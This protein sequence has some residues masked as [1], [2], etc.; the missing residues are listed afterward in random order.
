MNE[1]IMIEKIKKAGELFNE[2]AEYFKSDLMSA[3]MLRSD[4][5]VMMKKKEMLVQQ[6]NLVVEESKNIRR[7]AEIYAQNIKREADELLE[8]A[9][10][11]LSDAIITKENKKISDKKSKEDAAINAKLQAVG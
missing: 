4:I 9:K 6:N 7:D 3:R 1:D 10:R 8:K 11:T 5:D 2:I